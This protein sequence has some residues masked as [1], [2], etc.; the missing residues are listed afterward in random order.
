MARTEWKYNLSNNDCSV[1]KCYFFYIKYKYNRYYIY[2]YAFAQNIVQGYFKMGKSRMCIWVKAPNC[3]VTANK[4]TL[5][6]IFKFGAEKEMLSR[7]GIHGDMHP[8]FIYLYSVR[9][10]KHGWEVINEFVR[11]KAENYTLMPAGWSSSEEKRNSSCTSW[12][13]N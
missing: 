10:Q 9:K 2:I 13:V 5:R 11:P 6:S 12:L 7:V 4:I 3:P 8:L 1:S